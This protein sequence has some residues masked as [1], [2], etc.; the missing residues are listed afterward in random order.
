MQ[1]LQGD[2]KLVEVDESKTQRLR[3]RHEC[4][5]SSVLD[6]IFRGRSLNQF[7]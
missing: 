6:A 2:T 1:G 3:S 5:I 7:F 4:F